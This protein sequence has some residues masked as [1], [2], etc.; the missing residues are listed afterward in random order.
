MIHEEPKIINPCPG[1]HKKT[2]YNPDFDSFYCT[3]CNIWVETVCGQTYCDFCSN[4]PEKP[5]VG[6]K[7]DE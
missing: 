1:C 7:E 4:R 3:Y 2:L 6:T 5:N